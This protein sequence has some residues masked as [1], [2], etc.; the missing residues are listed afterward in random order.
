M[1]GG[2][3]KVLLNEKEIKA[4][5]KELAEQVFRDYYDK[6]PLIICV[7]K[8]AIVFLADFIRFLN[9]PVKLDF[10]AVA[11]YGDS[12]SSSGVVRIMKDLIAV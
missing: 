12:T 6:N 1:L 8:G 10:I 5:V 9:I 4:K 7:L 3:I 2:R 11:S